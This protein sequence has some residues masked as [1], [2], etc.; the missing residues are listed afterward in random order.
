M[1]RKEPKFRG[2]IQGVSGDC[3]QPGLGLSLENKNELV[4]NVSA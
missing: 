4:K 1:K 2:K 3:M